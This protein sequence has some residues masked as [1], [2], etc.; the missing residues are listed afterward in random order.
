M[1]QT[2]QAAVLHS[3]SYLALA[4]ESSIKGVTDIIDADYLGIRH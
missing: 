1:F 2:P 4:L 3:F